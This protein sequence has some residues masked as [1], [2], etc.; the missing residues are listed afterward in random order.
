[1]A[2]RIEIENN[3]TSIKMKPIN[4]ISM[5]SAC[6]L[7]I[8][9]AACSDLSEIED[10]IDSLESRVQAIENIIPALNGNIE[11][12]QALAGGGTINKVEYKDGVYTI[13]L[14]NGETLTIY[15][16][17]VGVANPPVM[18]IDKDGYWMVDYGTGAQHILAD[19]QKV[20]ATGDD[21]VTPQFGVDAEG[22]W[23]VSYDNGETWQQVAG[24]DGKPVSAIPQEGADEYFSEVVLEGE[25]FVITLKNGEKI[26]VPVVPSFSYTIEAEGVQV[27]KAGETKIYP[28]KSKGVA[29]AAV[30]AKPA[31]IEVSLDESSLTVRALGATKAV[32]ADS[33]KDI[34][35]LALSAEGFATIA[36][37]QVTVE[38]V[39]VDTTPRATVAAGEATCYTLAFSVA[40][41]N[42]ESYRYML[43]GA[44]EEAP[45]AEKLIAEGVESSE[46]TLV[47]ENLQ[48]A[49]DYVLY[50]LPLGTE[51]NGAVTKAEASTPAEAI[52]SVAVT[53]GEATAST[54]EFTVTLTDGTSYWY[55]I[56]KADEAVPSAEQIKA[57]GKESTAET[58]KAEGL[59]AQTRYILYVLPI[60][61]NTAGDVV[62]AEN[63]TTEPVFNNDYERYMAGR[64]ITVA[65]LTI[66]KSVYGDA[67]LVTNESESKAI[68]S[69]GVYFVD[70]TAEGVTIAG[71]ADQ[72][73]ILSL[74]ENTATVGRTS[75]KSLYVNASEGNDYFILSNVKYVTDMTS[76]NMMA[77]GGN[78]TTIETILFNKVKIEVPKDM[79]MLYSSKE[80]LNFNM[81]DCDVKLH[82]GSAEKNLVQSNTTSTYDTLV[83]KNNIFYSTD[84]DLTD[85]RLFSNNNATIASLEFKNNTVAGVYCKAAYGYVTV[86][87]ITAGDVVSNLFY[88]P[89]YT[90]Y[91]DGKY[92]G[93]LHIADKTDAHLNM[94]SNL[95][96]YNYD[97]VPSHRIKCSY[98][99]NN[100]TIYN[101]A[102]ADNPIPSPDYVNGVFTQGESYQSFGAKR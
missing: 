8:G 61:G 97:A 9:A 80:I 57:N 10:R 45:S 22:F 64:D 76:G 99:S 62:T 11:A 17:S 13:T 90:T 46:T 56:L 63:T 71:S 84:G 86:K 30:I 6:A 60:N 43:L 98:Y 73:I 34:A 50:V 51:K 91:L 75:G 44:S 79:L 93:I 25:T 67:V 101:K 78:G 100:G 49:S 102:K 36:K 14:S 15:Q 28:V 40:L 32:A 23:T 88:L 66:N 53:A 37:M 24:A 47:I 72:L 1:M 35:V 26:V 41:D 38:G 52:P 2:Q 69:K 33:R 19:G 29:S 20:S 87:S 65:D 77:G 81:T 58:L 21:G 74:D 94:V 55:A 12:L 5:F 3:N 54:L 68:G 96:F 48:P 82:V 27:I 42:S 92:T 85:Y 31:G 18:S 83:F 70:G 89:D 16:G 95:A 4:Y 7:L 59:D 39:A